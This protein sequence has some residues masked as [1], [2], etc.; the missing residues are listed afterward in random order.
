MLRKIHGI[1]FF[2]IK[3]FRASEGTLSHWPLHLQ[4][5]AHTNPHWARLVCYGPFSFCVIHKESLCSSSGDIN[6][7]V[8]SSIKLNLTNQKTKEI[9]SK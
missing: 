5:L 6:R 2:P 8:N 9:I 7:L 3:F 4:S 1:N